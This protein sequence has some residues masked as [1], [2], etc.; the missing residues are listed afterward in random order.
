LTIARKIKQGW[1]YDVGPLA[2]NVVLTHD[3]TNYSIF[4]WPTANPPSIAE[5]EAIVLPSV[6]TV[7]EV[8][9][10]QIRAWLVQTYGVGILAQI[11]AMIAAIEDAA[12][13]TLAQ[14]AWEYGLVIKLT[15]PLTL[16]FGAALLLSESQMAEAFEVASQIGV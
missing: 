9:P 5:I 2:P 4:H 8:T 11:D 1:G 7:T 10:Y 14:V 12:Q 6:P 15:D 16:Q 13:R 3:G